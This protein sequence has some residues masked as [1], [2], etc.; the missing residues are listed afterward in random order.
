MANKKKKE[1]KNAKTVEHDDKKKKSE[2]YQHPH[3]FPR[4]LSLSVHTK[5]LRH[6]LSLTIQNRPN[7]ILLFHL[8][9]VTLGTAAR[10]NQP[11]QSIWRTS[12]ERTAV[13][14]QVRQQRAIPKPLPRFVLHFN[15]IG[16]AHSHTPLQ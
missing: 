9:Y 11:H 12:T 15:L 2:F 3:V 16:N 13:Q 1:K 14:C 4:H 6:M 7:S 10:R 8:V 5:I